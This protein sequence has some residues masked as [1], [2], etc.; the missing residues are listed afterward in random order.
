MAGLPVFVG[1]ASVAERIGPVDGD[2]QLAVARQPDQLGTRGKPDFG[3]GVCA[4]S[5]AECLEAI[6]CGTAESGD[7]GDAPLVSDEG[8]RDI[9]GLVGA[10]EIECGVHRPDRA[11][12]LL[13]SGTVFDGKGAVPAQLIVACRTGGGD[14]RGT[15]GLRQLGGE[16]PHA[17][18]GAVDE[19]GIALGDV[20]GFQEVDSGLPGE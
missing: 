9:G 1:L 7:G 4:G 8:Q 15:A 18:C 5:A 3:A 12:A 14:H 19:H 20:G 11:D 17:A 2:L 16:Q 6:A 13:Q 10:D